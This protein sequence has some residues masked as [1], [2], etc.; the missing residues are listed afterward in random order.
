[1]SANT[2]RNIKRL[3][4][5]F[6]K[7]SF[8][9]NVFPVLREL[10]YAGMRECVIFRNEALDLDIYITSSEK[11]YIFIA[12]VFGVKHLS[13]D[14][15]V[16]ILHHFKY[17]YQTSEYGDRITVNWSGN[18]DRSQH[19]CPKWNGVTDRPCHLRPERVA[20]SPNL[21]SKKY[22]PPSDNSNDLDDIHLLGIPME[23]DDVVSQKDLERFANATPSS[24]LFNC[25]TQSSDV[26][27]VSSSS[28]ESKL[29]FPVNHNNTRG[30]VLTRKSRTPQQK[31]QFEKLLSRLLSGEAEIDEISQ[32]QDE[33]E[34]VDLEVL[35]Y[36][37]DKE[38]SESSESAVFKCFEKSDDGTF[39]LCDTIT[40]DH[41]DLSPDEEFSNI[42]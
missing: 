6:C 3:P 33:I 35:S 9:Y 24:P 38:Q 17:N 40:V 42:V 19:L 34:N 20:K 14:I 11:R 25:I 41:H 15:L 29:V 8:I 16:K 28:L 5:G 2:L 23:K 22:T 30:I 21:S 27:T 39:T 4:F 1:M 7:K 31:E 13:L 12:R 37:F 10:H 32:L 18:I 26:D 36:G